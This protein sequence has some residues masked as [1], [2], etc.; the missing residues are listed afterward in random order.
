MRERVL[1]LLEELVPRAREGEDRVLDLAGEMLEGAGFRCQLEV[2]DGGKRNLLA[3]RRGELAPLVATHPDVAPPYGQPEP[4]RARVLGGEV[5]GRGVIDALGQLAAVLAAAEASSGPALI[6]LFCNEEGEGKGSEF[7]SP[8]PHLTHLGAVILE[9][10]SFR[11]CSAQAGGVEVEV[12]AR[13]P[14]GHSEIPEAGQDALK[15]LL[16]FL[17]EAA[18]LPFARLSHPL[19]PPP[20]MN[21]G[22][23]EAGEGTWRVPG[24]ARAEVQFAVLPGGSA[25]EAASHLARLAEGN[26]E[27]RVKDVWEPF[28][29]PPTF[30]AALALSRAHAAVF[31]SPPVIAGMRSW[32]D[33]ENLVRKGVPAAIYGAGDLALAHSDR[34]KVSLVELERLAQVLTLF[35]S[36]PA[37]EGAEGRRPADTEEGP[38]RGN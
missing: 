6:A 38:L 27:V 9:P 29:L 17:G 14:G 16:F 8:P 4:D 5:W 32:T 15:L 1:E 7:F 26:L 30:P 18:T 19:F 36:S 31:G 33:A 11:L 25:Q 21:L 35:F 23:L 20:W 3:A 12:V 24:T 10:T 37:L 34:E 2:V 22:R 13:S 28:Q